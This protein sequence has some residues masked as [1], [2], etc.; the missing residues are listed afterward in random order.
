MLD[1]L[2]KF[3]YSKDTTD[4]IRTRALLCN[5]YHLALHG[6][7]Y[8]ARDLMLM[9]HLQE[10]IQHSDVPTQVAI[11]LEQIVGVSLIC[12]LCQVL[13]N[14]TIVQLGLCAFRKGL[15][16]DAHNTLQDVQSSGKAKELLAQVCV[17][18]NNISERHR[19]I[20]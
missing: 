5:V 12:L 18:L 2:C 3:I 14:R 4:R 6:H 13:Y 1:R 19:S 15:I 7:W 16:K 8:D 11:N 10:S 17:M 20:F 9:S